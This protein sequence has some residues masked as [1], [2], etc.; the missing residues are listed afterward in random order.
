MLEKLKEEVLEANLDLVRHGLVIHTWGNVS[1][2]D[3][4][5]G[6]IVIKPSGVSYSAMKA[7]DMV[8]LDRDGLTAEGRF[9][10]STDAPKS[11]S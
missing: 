3:P 4:E 11:L 8:V 1:A 7:G 6:F 10:P 2:R 5:T 9:K